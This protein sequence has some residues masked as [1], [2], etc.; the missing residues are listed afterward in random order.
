MNLNTWG[1]GVMGVDAP[2]P[3]MPNPPNCKEIG[4]KSL[5]SPHRQ[6]NTLSSGLLPPHDPYMCKKPSLR[7]FRN[8]IPTPTLSLTQTKIVGLLKFFIFIFN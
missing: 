5:P 2:L 1:C 6:L 3:T 4:P 8:N 7:V